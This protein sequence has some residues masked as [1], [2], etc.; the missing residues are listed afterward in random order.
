MSGVSHDPCEQQIDEATYRAS[1]AKVLRESLSG[2]D[3]GQG[4][5]STAVV[6]VRLDIDVGRAVVDDN[7]LVGSSSAAE[8]SSKSGEDG[9]LHGD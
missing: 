5:G 8:E 2:L 3:S 1:R 4:A 7:G 9:E 6:G